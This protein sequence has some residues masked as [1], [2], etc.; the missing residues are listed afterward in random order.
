MANCYSEGIKQLLNNDIAWDTSSYKCMLV[1]SSYTFDPD[2]SF[3]SEITNEITNSGYT[4]GGNAITTIAAAEDAGANEVECDAQDVTFTSLGAGDQPYAAIVY[5]NSG[6]GAG[7]DTLVAY[8]VLT[9]PPAPDGNNYVIQW[10]A[11]GVFKIT[12]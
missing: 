5:Y 4:A 1:T 8:C 3:R 10:S 11:E 9:T 2:H 7:S 12:Q 6:G